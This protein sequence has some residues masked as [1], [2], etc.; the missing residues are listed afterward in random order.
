MPDPSESMQNNNNITPDP[1]NDLPANVTSEPS[2][3]TAT[4]TATVTATATDT[5]TDT[6]AVTGTPPPSL[7]PAPHHHRHS[8]TVASKTSLSPS[9]P[10]SLTKASSVQINANIAE[11]LSK[12]PPQKTATTYLFS[13]ESSELS[14]LTDSEAETERMN[15]A[16][17]PKPGYSV[18]ANGRL[19]SQLMLLAKDNDELNGNISDP[20]EDAD[21]SIT[22]D[23]QSSQ[24][25]EAQDTLATDPKDLS[26]NNATSKPDGNSEDSEE[27]S[28]LVAT[29]DNKG[30]VVI[31]RVHNSSSN[32]SDNISG[33]SGDSVDHDQN[34]QSNDDSVKV[35]EEQLNEKLQVN[36]QSTDIANGHNQEDQNGDGAAAAT[37][38]T[39]A[40]NKEED[41]L[42]ENGSSKKRT[43][44]ES[45]NI[46]NNTVNNP[47][48][49]HEEENK[50]RK[51]NT[52]ESSNGDNL[53]DQSPS[54]EK[55]I[56]NG[57][58]KTEETE[59]DKSNETEEKPAEDFKKDGSL[60]PLE[61]T[62]EIGDGAPV[63]EEHNN[64]EE[65]EDADDEERQHEADHEDEHEDEEEEEE[66]EEEE[67]DDAAT[68]K[69]PITKKDDEA[70]VQ[71]KQEEELQ[72]QKYR[73][74]AIE[75]LT[76]IEIEFAK[77]KDKLYED[78]LKAFESEIQMC[79]NGSHPALKSVY[80]KIEDHRNKK[81]RLVQN[82]QKYQLLCID[83]QTRAQRLAIHQQFLKEKSEIKMDILD[84]T[85]IEWYDINRDRKFMNNITP[86][87]SFRASNSKPDQIEQANQINHEIDTLSTINK[88]FGFPLAP[89]IS[90]STAEEINEDLMALGIV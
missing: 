6:P 43:T 78:K 74:E 22:K 17:N 64:G 42:R 19:Q 87:Y 60:P 20:N 16:D 69:A 21:S 41:K 1:N 10:D 18:N 45:N 46:N 9:S 30:V 12:D 56:P 2:N 38:I 3:A 29:Q 88:N 8:A 66:E 52:T 79:L 44:D 72:R 76:E 33:K 49:H 77:L 47:G 73:K 48:E 70:A 31:K 83:R 85:T 37:T 61:T 15:Y 62:Q 89:R 80:E 63:E 57:E 71:K 7:P 81:L 4:A 75:K 25:S 65:E 90:S 40:A 13:S 68:K 5:D 86:E 59:Q 14:E 28:N 51:L 67:D 24:F 11:A 50:K 55:E 53:N 35:K 82:R 23:G 39:S 36:S 84:N 27:L 54:Q 34:H 32:S 58:T 26:T